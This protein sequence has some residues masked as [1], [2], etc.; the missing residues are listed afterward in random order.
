MA[1]SES[2]VTEKGANRG[3]LSWHEA[4][5]RINTRKYKIE[6]RVV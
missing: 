1:N 2:V 4:L 3:I 5:K 6:K